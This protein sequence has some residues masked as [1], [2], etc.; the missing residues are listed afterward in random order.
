MQ[1]AAACPK[2]TFPTSA[3]D[4]CRT[5]SIAIRSIH[6]ETMPNAAIAI[7]RRLPITRPSLAIAKGKPKIPPPMIVLERLKIVARKPQRKKHQD[8]QDPNAELRL[9]RKQKGW[10]ILT[11]M[12]F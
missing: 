3:Y 5:S 1:T 8:H 11:L 7:S 12:I 6:A 2:R 4:F 10:N 9:K